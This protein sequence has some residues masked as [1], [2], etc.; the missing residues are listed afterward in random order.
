LWFDGNAEEAA[1]FY[2]TLLRDSHVDKVW[3]SPADTPSGPA[4]LVL[5]VDFTL[6]GRQVQGLNGGPQ[7]IFNEAVSSLSTA[8]T[9]RRSI[10]V[11]RA[12]GGRRRA[13]S[14]R[15]A[16]GPL[17]LVMADRAAAPERVARAARSRPCA[18][19]MEA[20]LNMGKSMSRSW[21]AP[22]TPVTDSGVSPVCKATGSKGLTLRPPS[23]GE[24]ADC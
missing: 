9:R 16:Q 18:S 5:T 7:F 17:R 3:R 21:S 19:A 12:H 2:V 4:G 20:M 23:G 22:L 13:G 11:G 1:G 24:R 15:L 6:A 8:T 14:V 10:A